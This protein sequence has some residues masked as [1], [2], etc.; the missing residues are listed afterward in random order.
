MFNLH[1]E[2]QH[3]CGSLIKVSTSASEA[4]VGILNIANPTSSE[5]ALIPNPRVKPKRF[6]KFGAN[7]SAHACVHHGLP[8]GACVSMYVGCRFDYA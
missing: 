8:S 7:T 1:C 6:F 3:A 2:E 5:V 4:L